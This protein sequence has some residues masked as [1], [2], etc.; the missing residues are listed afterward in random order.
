MTSSLSL[1]QKRELWLLLLDELNTLDHNYP[2][3]IIE[4]GSIDE[5]MT[6][7]IRRQK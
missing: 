2:K 7:L 4:K 6:M 3:I 5:V 1:Q